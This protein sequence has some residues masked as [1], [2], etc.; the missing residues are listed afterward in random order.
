METVLQHLG[1]IKGA[2]AQCINPAASVVAAGS[3]SGGQA[4]RTVVELP[5]ICLQ[6]AA[7]H[8]PNPHLPYVQLM[9]TGVGIKDRY[10]DPAWGYTLLGDQECISPVKVL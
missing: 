9:W 1:N 2:T 5:T 6:R 7:R 10:E 4:S 3:W 8:L